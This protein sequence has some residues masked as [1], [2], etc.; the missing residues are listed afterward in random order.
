MAKAPLHNDSL[1]GGTGGCDLTMIELDGSTLSLDNAS[2]VV[3]AGERVGVSAA[4]HERVG[5]SHQVILDIVA[6]G[7]PVYGINTGLG[8]LSERQVSGDDLYELQRN[9]VL[10]HAAGVGEALPEDAVRAIL[11]F[12][13]N[14]F[15]QGNSGLRMEVIDYL[16][17]LLN[18]RIHPTIPAQGSVG[19]S[20]DLAPLAHL[21]LVLLGEGEAT[22]NGQRLSGREAL[23]RIGRAPLVLFPKEGLALLN[24]TQYM[25]GLGYLVHVRGERLIEAAIAAAALSFEALGAFTAALDARLHRARPHPG[26]VEVARRLRELVGGSRLVDTTQGDVHDAY[27]LRCTPQILG[28]AVEALAFLECKLLTEINASTDNPL[29]FPDGAVL[30][31]GNF[32]G[33]IIGL[34]LEMATIALAEA[35]NV[36]ERRINRLLTS[37]DRGLPPFLAHKPG[38][39]TGLMLAQYTAAALVSENKVLAHPALVDSI[40]TSGGKEDHNSMA[41]ISARKALQVLDNLDRVIAV[42]FLCAAQALD[43]RDVDRM[44]PQTRRVHDRIRSLVPRVDR[45]RPLS[46]DIERLAQAIRSGALVDGIL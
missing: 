3:F 38:V 30:S 11:L 41:S 44:A 35:G 28:P 40:P 25:A 10:S 5:R 23:A 4:A 9:T 43:F 27:S 7:R 32:H 13:V 20:G 12:R 37:T 17:D 18:A 22:C 26:Q 15:L 36:A 19:A 34:A 8:Q 33:E 21:A 2:R 14:S 39:E 42:E 16:V 1:P 45:D 24:G 29:V 6:R 31:G 46:Q